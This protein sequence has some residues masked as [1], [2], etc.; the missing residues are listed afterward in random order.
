MNE[1][2][3]WYFFYFFCSLASPPTKMLTVRTL[4]LWSFTMAS[5]TR[6]PSRERVMWL[7]TRMSSL[8]RSWSWIIPWISSR[9]LVWSVGLE[10]GVLLLI[11]TFVK[12][13]NVTNNNF[14]SSRREMSKLIGVLFRNWYVYSACKAQ[15]MI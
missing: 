10:N 14:E 6:L 2:R 12:I 13:E 3:G 11:N 7:L 4:N 15:G 8:E 1:F 5:S 9:Q